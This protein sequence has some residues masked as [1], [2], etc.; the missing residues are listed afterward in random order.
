MI[1]LPKDLGVCVLR[2]FMVEDAEASAALEY[3]RDV[4]WFIGDGMM[5]LTREQYVKQFPNKLDLIGYAI[6]AMDGQLAGRASLSRSLVHQEPN[7][8]IL[9]GTKFQGKGI[10]R[11]VAH[12]ILSD[13]FADTRAFA[14]RAEVHPE[15][16]ASLALLRSLGFVSTGERNEIEHDIYRLGRVEFR[17]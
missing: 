10:G 6:Q 8:T 7:I 11:S 9:L 15:N 13:W 2:E 17:A 3:D 1:E 4:K 16:S 5:K 12:C 14:V